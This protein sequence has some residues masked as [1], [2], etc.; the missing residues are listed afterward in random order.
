MAIAILTILSYTLYSNSKEPHPISPTVIT[1]KAYTAELANISNVNIGDPASLIYHNLLLS[2]SNAT[3]GFYWTSSA[4]NIYWNGIGSTQNQQT[5]NPMGIWV[6]KASQ[7]IGFPYLGTFLIEPVTANITIEFNG[8][9]FLFIDTSTKLLA[10]PPS[11][12]DQ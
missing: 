11:S 4:P 8:N 5:A 2:H 7:L 9:N 12:T 1:T 10:I 6:T 3:F